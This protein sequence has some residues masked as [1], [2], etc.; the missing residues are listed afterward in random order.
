MHVE[1]FD[2]VLQNLQSNDKQEVHH[3]KMIMKRSSSMREMNDNTI[4]KESYTWGCHSPEI[5]MPVSLLLLFRL[6]TEM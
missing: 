3:V 5:E 1:Y 6:F 2:A 4:L